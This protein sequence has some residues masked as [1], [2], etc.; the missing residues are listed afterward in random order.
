MRPTRP[1]LHPAD[2]GRVDTF[3]LPFNY[4][5][6]RQGSSVVEQGTH[7]PLVGSS[8]LPSGTSL[9][10]LLLLLI[11]GFHNRARARAPDRNRILKIDHEREHDYEQES[12]R[13]DNE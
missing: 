9:F 4:I 5:G 7:K 8:T 6:S 11:P 1:P 10:L 2:S 13:F 3:Y 12:D